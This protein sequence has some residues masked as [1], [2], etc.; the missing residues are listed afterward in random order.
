[1][2][3]AVSKSSSYYYIPVLCPHTTMYVRS[4]AIEALLTLLEGRQLWGIHGANWRQ[5]RFYSLLMQPFLLSP[6]INIGDICVAFKTHPSLSPE[7]AMRCV[8]A[9]EY[10]PL[11]RTN[12][13]ILIYKLTF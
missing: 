11:S 3:L 6:A 7:E 8:Y 12:F 4:Q 2:L 10:A 5:P 1:M 9:R 13:L